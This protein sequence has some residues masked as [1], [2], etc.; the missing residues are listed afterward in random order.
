MFL[1]QMF[2]QELG[3]LKELFAKMKGTSSSPVVVYNMALALRTVLAIDS[4]AYA[5][6]VRTTDALAVVT[7]VLGDYL[8]RVED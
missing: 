4:G 3:I 2:C 5:P 6:R 1:D 8:D 7:R